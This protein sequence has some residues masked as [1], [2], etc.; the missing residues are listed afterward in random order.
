MVVTLLSK[1]LATNNELRRWANSPSGKGWAIYAAYKNK[2]KEA[3]KTGVL[4]GCIKPGMGCK[5]E[6][7]LVTV[8]Y[9][10]KKLQDKD[11]FYASLKPLLD[12]LVELDCLIDDS[13]KWCDLK[14]EQISIPS[15]AYK[16]L[17]RI[18]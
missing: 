12:A 4:E 16:V 1:K 14:A 11:N 10:T 17:V 8:M 15:E 9:T 5:E 7:K 2:L 6:R 13:P 3:L 18:S